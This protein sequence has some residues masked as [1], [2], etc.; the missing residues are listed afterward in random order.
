MVFID[1]SSFL[2]ISIALNFSLLVIL[3]IVNFKD[4]R[5]QFREVK[6][7]TWLLL[8]LIFLL[9]L[10]LRF[11]VPHYHK[12]YRDEPWDMETGKN[13]LING[14]AE[15]C[16]YLDYDKLGCMTYKRSSGVPFIYALSFLIFGIDNYIA[17]AT[18]AFF[19]ALSSLLIFLLT[20]LF[21]KNENSA[22]Y[23]AFFLA[24]LPLHIFW[25]ASAQTNVISIFFLL[26]TLICFL[27]YF[28]VNTLRT[29]LLA[30][31]SSVYTIQT[32]TEAIIILP[33]IAIMF[34]LFDKKL[35]QRIKKVKF[36]VPFL[37]CLIFFISW[38][39]GVLEYNK[40]LKFNMLDIVLDVPNSLNSYGFDYFFRIAT[41]FYYPLIINIF[42][43]LYFPLFYITNKNNWSLFV[44]ITLSIVI[45]SIFC[46]WAMPLS[47]RFSLYFAMWLIP[48]SSYS[49]NFLIEKM[50]VMDHRKYVFSKLIFVILILFSFYPYISEVYSFIDEEKI[51]E[52]KIPEI[53]ERELPKNCIIIAPISEVLTATT[54]IKAIGAELI[55]E[56]PEILENLKKKT[57]CILFFE[58]W[59]CLTSKP[60]FVAPKENFDENLSSYYRN[61]L[62]RKNSTTKQCKFIKENYESMPYIRYKSLSENLTYGFYKIV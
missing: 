34:F 48:I 12:M 1:T 40:L 10:F 59:Y 11:T 24:I 57:D 45:F 23:S 52:T 30:I 58:D 20:F 46:I 49:A 26:L 9:G 44:F 38:I 33:I 39:F 27:I 13:I 6:R 51:L 4:I 8:I 50:K 29:L 2:A 15:L 17:I 62:R 36:W 16:Y 47:S 22:L 60:K 28:R 42:G 21:F 35:M 5:K 37:I 61:L 31:C 7:K 55:M 19:G 25:S 53:A 14:R 43:I 56:N 18:S 32:R 54:D 41:G 3:L